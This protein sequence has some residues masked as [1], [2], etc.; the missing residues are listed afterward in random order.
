MDTSGRPAAVQPS[1]P[2][3]APVP[4][5]L[6]IEARREALLE[7]SA[8]GFESAAPL[9][10]T[11]SA[12][13][14]RLGAG[15][16]RPAASRPGASRPSTAGRAPRLQAR[17]QVQPILRPS[18]AQALG[19]AAVSSSAGGAGAPPLSPRGPDEVWV[20]NAT[21]ADPC[22]LFGAARTL[23][24]LRLRPGQWAQLMSPSNTFRPRPSPPAA[25]AVVISLS[26]PSSTPRPL[27][28]RAFCG[29]PGSPRG[30]PTLVVV[31]S[32]GAPLLVGGVALRSG[33][34]AEVALCAA[35]GVGAA[36]AAVGA[37]GAA[38]AGAADGDAP[39]LVVEAACGRLGWG[40]CE[41]L[42][43]IWARKAGSIS[44][45]RRAAAAP[46]DALVALLCVA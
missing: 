16:A 6:H 37:A 7:L 35:V 32:S 34:R 45:Q 23:R 11:V 22:V 25:P 42:S 10:R 46:P 8:A 3:T 28:G 17:L 33:A 1:R 20:C 30:A 44:L 24:S 29:P 26:P 38:G 18:T 41:Q 9:A 39:Q 14:H 40:P 15:A 12:G 19:T 43:V 5:R 2:S 13:R 21:A 36:D 27:Y 4:H 31:N